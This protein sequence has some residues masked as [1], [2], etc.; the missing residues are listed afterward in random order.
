MPR[1]GRK[2]LRVGDQQDAEGIEKIIKNMTHPE[3]K[4]SRVSLLL[5]PALDADKRRG[6]LIFCFLRVSAFLCVPN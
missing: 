5:M 6:T 1:T 3:I 2:S 4:V